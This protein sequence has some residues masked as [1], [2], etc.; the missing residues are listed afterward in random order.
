MAFIDELSSDLL[1]D[2]MSYL[3]KHEWVPNC[4]SA[5][6]TARSCVILSHHNTTTRSRRPV[7]ADII[8][9][10]FMTLWMSPRLAELVR[11]LDLRRA[12]SR[13]WNVG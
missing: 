2:I 5:S 10:L 8:Y 12:E 13:K 6:A 7:K 11:K 4:R 9:P 1:L 3:G